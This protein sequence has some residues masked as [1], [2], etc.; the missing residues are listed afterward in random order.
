[1]QNESNLS[2]HSK[3]IERQ[4]IRMNSADAAKWTIVITVAIPVVVLALGLFMWLRR[5]KK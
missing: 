1:V 5:R 2:I 3:V 4:Y